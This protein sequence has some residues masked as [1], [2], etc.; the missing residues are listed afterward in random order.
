MTRKQRLLFALILLIAGMASGTVA[1][2]N[3]RIEKAAEDQFQ[4]IREQ[5]A[6]TAEESVSEEG[7]Y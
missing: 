1:I 7:G 3:Y 4:E 5:V 2:N 6:I